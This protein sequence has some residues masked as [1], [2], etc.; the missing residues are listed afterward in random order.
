MK[1]KFQENVKIFIMVTWG[2]W[3]R[4]RG[5]WACPR[6]WF[7]AS[8]SRIGTCKYPRGQLWL[9]KTNVNIFYWLHFRLLYFDA[10]P[11][12]GS[13]F[14]KKWIRIR[15]RIQVIDQKKFY[16]KFK[17]LFIP[18]KNVKHFN[19]FLYYFST[20][21]HKM[22]MIFFTLLDFSIC[23]PPPFSPSLLHILTHNLWRLNLL[24]C[25]GEKG[26]F[27]PPPL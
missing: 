3:P 16:F 20:S 22:I 19:I 11:D 25:N 27:S 26:D 8:S 7:R 17:Y 9:L 23:A 13:A 12:P 5:H 21:L 14:Q 1:L 15:I 4:P 2:F 10:D 24:S 6:G 18:K